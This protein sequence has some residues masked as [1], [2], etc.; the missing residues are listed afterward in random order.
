MPSTPSF[1]LPSFTLPSFVKDAAYITVGLG[2]LA[3]QRAQVQRV[4]LQKQFEGLGDTVE[5]RLKVV[6]ERL[7]GLGDQFDALLDDLEDRLPEQARD[8]FNTARTTAKEAQGQLRELV[9]RAA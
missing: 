5:D 7:E 6:E 4:E 1:S 8:A 3:F 9:R 2:V